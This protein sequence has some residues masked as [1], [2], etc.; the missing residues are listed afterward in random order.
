MPLARYYADAQPLK[1]LLN[2]TGTGF[3]I[4]LYQRPYRWTSNH[5]SRLIADIVDG[6]VRFQQTGRSSTF[7]GSLITVKDSRSLVP[8]PIDRPATVRQVIDGQQRIATLLALCG[9]ARRA[10]RSAFEDLREDDRAVLEQVVAQQSHELEMALSFRLAEPDD[11]MLPRM[12]RGGEDR[13]AR[14]GAEYRSEIARYL[15]SY[16]ADGTVT[17]TGSPVFDEVVD[18]IR[19]SFSQQKLFDGRVDTLDD[20]QWSTLFSQSAP[21]NLPESLEAVRLLVLLTFAAFTMGQ[22]QVI[23]V[24]AEDEESAFAV[25]EPLNTTGEPL[26]AFETFLPLV[27]YRHGGQ[28]AYANSF[29]QRQIERFRTLLHGQSARDVMQR[30]KRAL[31]AFALSDTGI[32]LGEQLRDQRMYLRRYLSLGDTDQVKFLNGLGDTGECLANT[33]YGT[34]PLSASSERT[35]VA[36]KMLIESKHTIPQGLMI[37]G[38]REFKDENPD[39]LDR[40]VLVVASFWLLWRL[41]RSTTGNIDG[42]YR[43]LMAGYEVEESLLGPYC[44]RPGDSTAKSPHP[45]MLAHDFRTILRAK[46]GIGG[47]EAWITKVSEVAHGSRGNKALIRYALLGAYHDALPG[48]F[49]NILRPG[50]PGSSPT[51]TSAWHGAG[52]TLEHIA[53]Q[54]P[55][56]GDN[57]FTDQIYREGR[58]HRLGNLTLVPKEE[59][60]ILGNKPW[61]QK[62]EYF[63]VFAERDPITRAQRVS[64]LDLRPATIDF[65][66]ERFVPFCADLAE[67]E[68]DQ[69]TETNVVD[70]GRCLAE[71]IWDQFSP[72][73]NF[74][75]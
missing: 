5:A 10:I 1:D 20:A 16:E 27:V 23:A 25:F 34:H 73:L 57:S 56:S 11:S 53:P 74:S 52:L 61:P 32:G 28:Q 44:Q 67:I 60:R 71:L 41:S 37:Q 55:L 21:D 14:V 51:L 17:A 26:T 30:T 35:R 70:R 63:R 39:L 64:A 54:T 12:I 4:P 59:N 36:L 24:E 15:S 46:G 31:V 66:S 69:W 45:D 29:G 58:V 13:W 62:Q 7:L 22:V 50:T 42:H 38:Y 47:R 43:N 18:T 68:S 48:T 6:I 19:D 2:A 9:E 75:V 33:W 3:Y 72:T 65:L 8:A 49:P 40:L